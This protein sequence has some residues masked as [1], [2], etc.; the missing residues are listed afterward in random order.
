MSFAKIHMN[1]RILITGSEGYLGSVIAPFLIERGYD[2][3]GLDIGLF[4]DALLYKA[5]HFRVIKKDARNVS[6][7]DLRGIDAVVHLAGISI[8]DPFGNLP[9]EKLYGPTRE[10]ARNIAALCKKAGVKFIFASSCSIYGKSGEEMLNEDS[11]VHP[12]IDYAKNK[13]QVE[14]DLA[15]LADKSF[16]PIALRFATAFGTSPRMRFDIVINMFAG[17]AFT[18]KKITLNSD[19]QAWRPNVHISDIARAVECALRADYAGGKLLVLNVGTE[20]NNM[21][22]ADIANIVSEECGGTPILFAFKE[23]RGARSA[24]VTSAAVSASGADSRNYRVSFALVK[25]Y[26]PDFECKYSV[27]Y[28]VKEMLAQFRKINMTP[29]QFRDR[30]FYRIKRLEDLYSKGEIDSEVRLKK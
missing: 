17:M 14:E 28:G 24:F 5:P 4:N 26:F 1:K 8:N 25:E 7:R 23:A 15:L 20:N 16:S 21:K 6:A 18:E 11:V 9:P 10:Y 22:I 29:A 3:T 27:R 19:G 13:L 12:Q 30:G 2:T